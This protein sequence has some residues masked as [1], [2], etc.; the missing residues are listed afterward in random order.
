LSRALLELSETDLRTLASALRSGRI[1]S[2]FSA[3]TLQRL[4]GDHV[5][6]AIPEWM[7]A[8]AASGCSSAAMASFFDA[9]ADGVR[10]RI[11]VEHA[12]QLVTTAPE[13]NAALHRDTAVVVQDLFRRAG[14]S[15][16]ISTYAFYGGRE[17]FQSLAERM[18]IH[19]G[20]NVRIFVNIERKPDDGCATNEIVSRFVHQFREYHWPAQSRLPQLYYDVRSTDCNHLNLAVLHAKCIVIDGEELFV[21]SAN[22]TEAAQRR[23]IETGVLVKSSAIADQ[24]TRFFDSL[25]RSGVC[26]K[27]N[28]V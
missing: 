2:P 25:I 15:V 23:N 20:L 16:L 21:T 27:A 8:V 3:F 13:G 9:F 18:D 19:P 26:V 11:P 24:A 4:I 6:A 1:S 5:S 10:E 28:L 12:V 22:F 7:T 17:I 14:K